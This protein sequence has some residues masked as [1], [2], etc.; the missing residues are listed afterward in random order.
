VG[1]GCQAV[2]CVLTQLT[3]PQVAVC[4]QRPHPQILGEAEGFLVRAS[5]TTGVE[6]LTAGEDLAAQALGPRGVASFLA[7][8]R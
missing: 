4:Y 1:L 7:L 6:G 8:A 3:N 5:G 2:T